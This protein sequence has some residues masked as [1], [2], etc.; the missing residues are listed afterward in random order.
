MGLNLHFISLSFS[1]NHSLVTPIYYPVSWLRGRAMIRGI[2]LPCVLARSTNRLLMEHGYRC[3]SNAPSGHSPQFDIVVVGGGIVGSATARQLKME[4]PKMRICQVEKEGK[5]E[6]TLN[7]NAVSWPNQILLLLYST[8]V[9]TSSLIT[10][11]AIE[12]YRVQYNYL[13]DTIC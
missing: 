2:S 4:H 12:C 5:L 13:I 11:N 3:V 6:S 10:G 1:R 7:S 8:N 9:V